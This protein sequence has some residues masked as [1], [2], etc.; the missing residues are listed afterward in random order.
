MNN[1]Q[2]YRYTTFRV[3]PE[4]TGH[5]QVEVEPEILDDADY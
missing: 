1:S 5:T 2:G 3:L 4:L